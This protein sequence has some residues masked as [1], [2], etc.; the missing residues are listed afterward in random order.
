MKRLLANPFAFLLAVML[1][2]AGVGC[3]TSATFKQISAQN[4]PKLAATADGYVRSDLQSDATTKA[5]RLAQS[6][7][8]LLAGAAAKS[9][10]FGEVYESW[11]DV[12]PWLTAYMDADPARIADPRFAELGKDVIAS[13]DHVIESER[14]R[15]FIWFPLTT[16]L[17]PV[18]EPQ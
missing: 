15:R 16:P 8:L 18:Y 1:A 14:K 17:K 2:L 12:R 6:N 7:R 3:E 13:E 5:V 10:R 9:V 4:L 11:R